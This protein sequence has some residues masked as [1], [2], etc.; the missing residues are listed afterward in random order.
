MRN[1]TDEQKNLYIEN[2]QKAWDITA[3]TSFQNYD[4]FVSYAPAQFKITNQTDT[5]WKIPSNSELTNWVNEGL[6]KGVGEGGT[7]LLNHNIVCQY[8]EPGTSKAYIKLSRGFKSIEIQTDY[9]NIV[10]ADKSLI[11][12]S[13]L[14]DTTMYNTGSSYSGSGGIELQMYPLKWNGTSWAVYDSIPKNDDYVSAFLLNDRTGGFYVTDEE[15]GIQRT[16]I[17][18]S[19]SNSRWQNS[20]GTIIFTESPWNILL[21]REE[22]CYN[23]EDIVQNAVTYEELV[24]SS[25]NLKYGELNA[26][27]FR[28]STGQGISIPQG[29]ML[30]VWNTASNSGTSYTHDFGT[31]LV[32][33]AKNEVNTTLCNIVAYDFMTVLDKSIIYYIKNLIN[34]GFFP[35]QLKDLIYLVLLNF[36]MTAKYTL[37]YDVFDL[38]LPCTA[39]MFS[40]IDDITGRELLSVL[41]EPLGV[42]CRAFNNE[43]NI[44]NPDTTNPAIIDLYDPTGTDISEKDCN[45]ITQIVFNNNGDYITAGDGINRYVISDNIFLEQLPLDNANSLI[46]RFYGATHYKYRPFSL[47]S[48]G[49]PYI[50]AGDCVD[51]QT[52][53]H[54][55]LSIILKRTMTGTQGLQDEYEATGDDFRND[56]IEKKTGGKSSGGG[57][58]E[59][60]KTDIEEYCRNYIEDLIM[61]GSS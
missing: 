42:F 11:F 21:D 9:N 32:D 44:F 25:Q 5:T 10:K 13:D 27:S 3:L 59:D 26:S 30:K 8:V 48:P 43:L 12:I 46:T 4:G 16:Y 24:C 40:D 41:L 28:F 36:G 56:K 18:W 15:S 45:Y 47:T 33:E 39:E 22:I 19:E 1:I 35:L 57:M 54:N 20:A 34:A 37:K 49:L 29:Q 31:F 61:N 23:N 38:S 60:D 2:S 7:T 50:E 53:T 14:Y 17:Y 55:C 51:I 58:S 52:A 6:L